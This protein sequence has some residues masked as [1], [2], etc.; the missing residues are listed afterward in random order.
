MARYGLSPVGRGMFS[1]VLPFVILGAMSGEQLVLGVGFGIG[2]LMGLGYLWSA[3][4]LKPVSVTAAASG[5]VTLGESIEVS[6]SVSGPKGLECAVEIMGGEILGVT[7]PATGSVLA[8]ANQMGRFEDIPIVIQTGV[9]DGIV[10]AVQKRKAVLAEPRY[11]YPASIYVEVP[12]APNVNATVSSQHG[13]LTGLREYT[14]GDKLRDVHWPAVARSGAVLVRDRR[15][16]TSPGPVTVALS[17]A[18]A[19]KTELAAGMARSAIQTLTRRGHK[20]SLLIGNELAAVES[21]VGALR[22]LAC[23][24]PERKPEVGPIAG[25]ILMVDATRGATWVTQA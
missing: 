5:D 7:I 15:T 20:V 25:P 9:P 6:V 3:V 14:P 21:E 19:A 2:L 24:T 13:E 10:G 17:Y 23:L 16:P 1:L 8:V 11:V 22:R 12:Q 4:V 18:E